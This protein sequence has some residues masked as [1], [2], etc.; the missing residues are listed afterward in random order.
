[1]SNFFL[2]H[3]AIHIITIRL[4]TNFRYLTT[5]EE[6]RRRCAVGITTVEVKPEWRGTTGGGED[7]WWGEGHVVVDPAERLMVV[8]ELLLAELLGA[9]VR[10]FRW[11]ALMDVRGL[12]DL[13]A[14]LR[15]EY[16]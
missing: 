15:A 5:A 1:M 6:I 14:E 2:I 11:V 7:W 10:Y 9:E 16:M 13:P 12:E 8:P 3:C 4:A